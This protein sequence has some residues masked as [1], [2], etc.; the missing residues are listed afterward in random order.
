[1]NRQDYGLRDEEFFILKLYRLHETKYA[2]TG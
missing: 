1:M 2:L